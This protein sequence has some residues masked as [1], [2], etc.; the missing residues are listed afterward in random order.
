VATL[1]NDWILKESNHFSR[2][3]H[4]ISEKPGFLS[5]KRI[6]LYLK[7]PSPSLTG[8]VSQLW[9]GE[10]SWNTRDRASQEHILKAIEKLAA[11]HSQYN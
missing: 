6:P 1:T 2:P 5:E 11:L 7:N 4:R 10:P 9:E 8:Q 3:G